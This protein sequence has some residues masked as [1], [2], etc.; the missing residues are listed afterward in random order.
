MT[1]RE[2]LRLNLSDA[3]RR[4]IHVQCPELSAEI[5]ERRIDDRDFVLRVIQH[6]EGALWLLWFCLHSSFFVRVI[7]MRSKQECGHPCSLVDFV[8]L[9]CRWSSRVLGD[10]YHALTQ[11]H[12]GLE[13]Y[14]AENPD[15]TGLMDWLAIRL[16]DLFHP[17]MLAENGSATLEDDALP[18]ALRQLFLRDPRFKTIFV[19]R[20]LW[21]LIELEDLHAAVI[22]PLPAETLLSWIA[23][24]DETLLAG[25]DN[26][27]L[28]Q[29]EGLTRRRARSGIPPRGAVAGTV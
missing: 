25:E 2:F 8:E 12:S 1:L 16:H 13:T 9:P 6:D 15:V 21:G 10:F 20:W 29:L 11:P 22:P 4:V 26:G 19:N 24:V 7:R 3:Q 23:Q 5:D 14:C 28:R 17:Q 18:P 27:L